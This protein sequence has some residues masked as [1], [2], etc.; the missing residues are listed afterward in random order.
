MQQ[1]RGL[2]AEFSGA[3]LWMRVAIAKLFCVNGMW[4][5]TWRR[6]NTMYGDQHSTNTVRKEIVIMKQYV[7]ENHFHFTKK[8]ATTYF[9]IILT[10]PIYHANLFI[11]FFLLP[12][13]IQTTFSY[14]FK[15]FDF[16]FLLRF[17]FVKGHIS[18]PMQNRSMKY[19]K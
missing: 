10:L 3:R 19:N 6:S 4:S 5:Y 13:H 15:Y 14:F 8:Q 18:K 2:A 11:F 12:K 17:F 7:K 16:F 1:M 9:Y